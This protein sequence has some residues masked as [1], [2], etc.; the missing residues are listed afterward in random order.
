MKIGNI[1]GMSN[2]ITRDRCTD[3]SMTSRN[4]KHFILKNVDPAAI[5]DKYRFSIDFNLDRK[6]PP[7]NCTRIDQV[8]F[9]DGTVT[10][11]TPHDGSENTTMNTS[12]RG[13]GGT[14]PVKKTPVS[15][16]P[17]IGPSSSSS[18]PALSSSSSSAP[19]L[20]SGVALPC[21]KK[22]SASGF[23]SAVETPTIRVIHDA[24]PKIPISI[25]IP[26]PEDHDGSE[27]AFHHHTLWSGSR[28]KGTITLTYLDECKKEHE[29][30][31]TMLSMKNGAEQTLLHCFWCRHPFP[32]R[33]LSVPIAY[34]PNRLHKR[35][36]SEIT[37]DSYILREN[38]DRLESL[39]K[40]GLENGPGAVS[41]FSQPRDYYITDGCFCSFNC[42]LAF[43]KDNRTDPKYNDSETLLNKIYYE[44]Y[45]S[46]STPFEASPSWRLLRNYG[47]HLTIEDFRRNLLK[48][49][50]RPLGNVLLPSFRPIGFLFEKQVRI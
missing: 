30:V 13:R 4:V 50:Y 23:C 42:A 5:D 18:A 8:S 32:Y 46:H 29:C 3:S 10:V 14:Y 11:D 37:Q 45:G 39:V 7:A 27:Q 24:L 48:I 44:V 38:I 35:Y 2:N 36:H 25:D 28:Q 47:G 34:V 26:S 17:S 6:D 43:I 1:L 9:L 19:V 21:K 31:A 15:T 49:D 41:V 16:M 22:P 33:P 12:E 40:D 20:S